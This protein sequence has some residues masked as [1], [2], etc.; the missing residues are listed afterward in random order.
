MLPVVTLSDIILSMVMMNVVTVSVIMTYL[1][2][3]IL[4]SAMLSIHA[5]CYNVV[6][7]TSAYLRTLSTTNVYREIG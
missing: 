3:S 1:S 5:E 6:A 7:R 4:S 2:V